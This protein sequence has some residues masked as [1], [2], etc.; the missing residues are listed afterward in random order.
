MYAGGDPTF[1]ERTGQPY[2]VSDYFP[3]PRNGDNYLQMLMKKYGGAAQGFGQE[4]GDWFNSR[5]PNAN[6]QYQQNRN[7]FIDQRVDEP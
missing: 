7:R 6:R 4:F 2:G 1:N 3:E 5:M